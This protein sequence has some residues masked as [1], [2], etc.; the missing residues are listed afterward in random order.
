MFHSNRNGNL[1]RVD[2]FPDIQHSFQVVPNAP[3]LCLLTQGKIGDWAKIF[4]IGQ[5]IHS[6]QMFGRENCPL[7]AR[8][9]GFA[10]LRGHW[11]TNE[12]H[13]P[14]EALQTSTTA[15]IAVCTYLCNIG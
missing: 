3:A 15:L 12:N 9:T 8:S 14:F 5:E 6:H 7:E 2:G 1:S 11:V 4:R 13:H 10:A